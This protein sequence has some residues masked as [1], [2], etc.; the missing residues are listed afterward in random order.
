MF[1][2]N[3]KSL[4]VN[5]G[6]SSSTE[7]QEKKRKFLISRLGRGVR[8]SAEYKIVIKYRRTDYQTNRQGKAILGVR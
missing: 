2:N 4:T 7:N 1:H 6:F 8:L 3:I 5:T